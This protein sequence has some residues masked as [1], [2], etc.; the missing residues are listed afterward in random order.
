MTSRQ[1]SPPGVGATKRA[2]VTAV[3]VGRNSIGQTRWL[4]SCQAENPPEV[5]NQPVESNPPL[6]APARHGQAEG[7]SPG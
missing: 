1:T 7:D 3:L 5:T 2:A 4:D 6:P